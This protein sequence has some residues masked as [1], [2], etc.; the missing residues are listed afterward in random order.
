[1]YVASP[2]RIVVIHVACTC[3][4]PNSTRKCNELD[5]LNLQ[6]FL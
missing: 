6:S 4:A 1:M 3:N 5:V 2:C